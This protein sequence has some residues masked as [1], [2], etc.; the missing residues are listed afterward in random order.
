[1]HKALKIALIFVSI[2]L[3]L[4]GAVFLI[5]GGTENYVA[6]GAMMLVAF[7]LLLL[8]YFSSRREARRPIHQEFHVTMGG[9]GEL[10]EKEMSCRSCGGPIG[11]QDLTVVKGGIV[12]KCPYCGKTYALEEEPKW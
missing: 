9:A 3:L 2:C 1:M 5:A 7:G 6:G 10:K 11:D 12:V 8:L 4:L